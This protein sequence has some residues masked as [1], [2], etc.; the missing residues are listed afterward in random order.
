VDFLHRRKGLG[1]LSA[2]FEDKSGMSWKRFIT[3]HPSSTVG[4]TCLARRSRYLRFSVLRWTALCAALLCMLLVEGCRLDMHIEPRYDWDSASSYFPD[5]R[6]ERPMVPGTVARGHLRIDELLYTGKTNGQY[7]NVF[8]FSIT[9]KDLDRGQQRYDIYCTPCHGF[10][11]NANGLVVQRGFPAPPD[12]H[13]PKIMAMPVGQFFSVMTN[14][15]G[16]M[17]SFAYRISVKDRW[18][19][20]AYIRVLQLSQNVNV[21][22]I[23]PAERLRLLSDK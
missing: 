19:I 1:R 5:G 21:K 14:G 22:Q 3:R 7:A 10:T 6:S 2:E 17:Y 15:F 16:A 20:A 4:P 9:K 11:G 18:R 12:Y 8:P 23:S 13:S